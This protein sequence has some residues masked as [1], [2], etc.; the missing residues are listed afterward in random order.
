MVLFFLPCKVSAQDETSI[1][2]IVEAGDLKKLLKADEY[3]SKAEKLIEEANQYNLEI[4]SVQANT[5]LDEKIVLKKT[6]QLEKKAW[7][8]QIE[9]SALYEESNE[10]KFIVYKKYLDRFWKDHAGEESDYLNAKLLEEQSSDNY[11][12]ATSYRIEAKK[13]PDGAARVQKLSEANELEN[14]AIRKQLSALAA[15]YDIQQLQTTETRSGETEVSL[16]APPETSRELPAKQVTQ[17]QEG[18]LPG[19]V[20]VNQEMIDMYNEY[21]KSGQF[22]DTTLSTGKIAGI[23]EFDMDR[24]LQIWYE[25]MYGREEPPVSRGAYYAGLSDSISGRETVAQ[26]ETVQ[27]E[28]DVEIG[29]VTDENISVLVPADENVIYRVQIAANRTELSQRA[30]SRIYY[31]NKNVEMINEN[32]W[33]KYSVGDFDTYEE[34][35][36]FRKSSGVSNAFVVAYRKG[37]RFS[38][39]PATP[40]AGQEVAAAAGEVQHTPPGLVFRIQIAASR[41]PITR[42]QLEKIYGGNYS[43]EMIREEGWYKYQFLGLRLY[44]D[45]I[46]IIKDV[47][48]R[49]AFIVAYED[50]VKQ[51]L[52]DAVRKNR[53]TEN[54][55]KTYGRKG[56]IREVEFHVQLAASKRSMNANELANLYHGPEPLSLVIEEGW[57]KYR[58]KTGNSYDLAQKIKQECGVN[59]AFIVAYRRAEKIS[60]YEAIREIK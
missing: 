23:T 51:N 40:Q 48:V 9:A 2:P 34:A 45:A 26:Q 6:G 49:G 37:T 60:L 10:L 22:T 44:S 12:Q 30:L 54:T 25:Y 4:F 58:I 14:E 18:T 7:D 59:D 24:M 53:E 33:Y 15:Y 17:Q 36:Q 35:S 11:F 19:Q 38:A 31:G 28:S 57:Y 13:M 20:E 1:R 29:V 16:P 3:Q 39:G 46:R 27:P 56:R 5:D 32:G 42:E 41:A 21:L 43:V 47:P 50:G 8:K 55:V 52:A